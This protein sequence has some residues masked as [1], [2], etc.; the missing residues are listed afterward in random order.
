MKFR[1]FAGPFD[2]DILKQVDAIYS[3]PDNRL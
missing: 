3:D 1:L 2:D